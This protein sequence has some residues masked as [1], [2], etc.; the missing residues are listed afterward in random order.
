LLTWNATEGWLIA[1]V[2]AA[3]ITFQ[4]RNGYLK[5]GRRK[6]LLRD[7]NG[8]YVWIELNGTTITSTVDPTPVWDARDADDSD[9]E[10]GGDGGD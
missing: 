2:L 4:L 3:V 5:R 1:T 9:G 6:S 10:D 8:V 7:T